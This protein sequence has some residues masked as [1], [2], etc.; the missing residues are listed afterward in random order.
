MAKAKNTAT[1][2]ETTDAGIPAGP[3]QLKIQGLLFPF[4]SRY[5]AGHVLTGEEALVLDQTLA[6]NLR[7][8][9]ASKIR[10][11]SDEIAKA[12]PEGETPRGFTEEELTAFQNDFQAYASSYVFRAPR[13]GSGPQDPVERT[14]RKIA[15]EM[16]MAALSAKNIKSNSLPEGKMEEFI[17]AVLSRKPEIMEEAKRRVEASKTSALDLLDTIG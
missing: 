13:A 15:K 7:N 2:G 6:E 12:T 3:S 14:A 1:A 5:A 17:S 16:V 8:N 9:F 11:K 10:A 4:I